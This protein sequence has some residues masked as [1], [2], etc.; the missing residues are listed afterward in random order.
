MS[1]PR[2]PESVILEIKGLVLNPSTFD[3]KAAD[4]SLTVANNVVIDRPS[5]V[6][7]RRGF[8]NEFSKLTNDG[9]LSMYQYNNTKLINT[10]D[11]DLHADKL[12]N[13][14]LTTYTGSYP[15]PDPSNP[16][17]RVRGLETNKNFYFITEQ[18][19]YRLDH[20]DGQ[21][22]LAGAPPG[23]NGYGSVF[24]TSGFLPNNTQIA[25]RVVFGYKDYNQQLVLGAPSSR[26]IVANSGTGCLLYTS[27][28]ADE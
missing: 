4:G 20:I 2:V 23:L 24:G 1:Q 22:R 25:Y 21:P 26:I 14:V 5:V 27:D 11:H 16:E 12:N 9:A 6:A 28:A 8:N 17:S 10:S 13:G 15:Q 19:T 3:P 7:T 18:G